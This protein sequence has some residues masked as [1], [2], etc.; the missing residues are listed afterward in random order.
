MLANIKLSFGLIVFQIVIFQLRF[1]PF[2]AQYI[3]RKIRIIAHLVTGYVLHKISKIFPDMLKLINSR[4]LHIIC[5]QNGVYKLLLSNNL[6]N[7]GNRRNP[8]YLFDQ[9]CFKFSIL[10]SSKLCQFQAINQCIKT[11]CCSLIIIRQHQWCQFFP[12]QQC[13]FIGYSIVIFSL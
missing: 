4:P 5:V 6:R 2:V 11:H 12:H 13:I 3:I 9:V 1:I 10:L 8:L 7:I